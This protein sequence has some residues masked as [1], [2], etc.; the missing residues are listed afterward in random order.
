M[1]SIDRYYLFF[2]QNEAFLDVIQF[3]IPPNRYAEFKLLPCAN[4][5]NK[6]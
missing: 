5:D 2:S 4:V 6:F 1:S 3:L